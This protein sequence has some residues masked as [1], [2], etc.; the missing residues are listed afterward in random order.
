VN[1]VDVCAACLF[2]AGR[3]DAYIRLRL[4]QSDVVECVDEDDEERDVFLY[5]NQDL[6]IKPYMHA[7]LGV[8]E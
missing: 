8:T 4:K 1:K 5:P 6:H 7:E 2:D 3:V